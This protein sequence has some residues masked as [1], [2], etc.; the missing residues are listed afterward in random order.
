MHTHSCPRDPPP[1]CT[2]TAAPQTHTHSAPT[3][4]LCCLLQIFPSSV[5]WARTGIPK[6][7]PEIHSGIPSRWPNPSPYRYGAHFYQ[8]PLLA[9]AFCLSYLSSLCFINVSTRAGRDQTMFG[10]WYTCLQFHLISRIIRSLA[11]YPVLASLLFCYQLMN[12][13]SA[14]VFLIFLTFL[15]PVSRGDQSRV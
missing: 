4:Q 11:L 14:P 12:L 6:Q 15:A 2:R 8:G 10:R 1:L 13:G 5:F 7:I 9:F 3:C